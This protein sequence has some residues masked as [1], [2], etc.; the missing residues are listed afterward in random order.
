MLRLFRCTLAVYMIGKVLTSIFSPRLLF[1]TGFGLCMTGPTAE[2]AAS[3]D[4]FTCHSNHTSSSG[5]EFGFY[6]GDDDDETSQAKEQV[7]AAATVIT[8]TSPYDPS[9]MMTVFAKNTD[10]DAQSVCLSTTDMDGNTCEWCNLAGQADLCLTSEQADM[11]AA[12][13]LACS[14]SYDDDDE[15]EAAFAAAGAAAARV[16]DD[17]Y[18]PS[19]ALAF[20][21]DQTKEACLAAVDQDGKACEYCTLQDALAL[22][23]TEEQAEY[24]QA[25]GIECD[26]ATLQ[27]STLPEA[28]HDP[29]DSTCA[30]AFLQDQS[31][32]GCE[33]AVDQD[34]RACEWC[35]LPGSAGNIC[36]NTD[37]AE[38]AEQFGVTCN[39][40]GNDHDNVNDKKLRG[41]SQAE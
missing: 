36:L 20:L 25:M 13:G 41:V 35:D 34:G 14:N 19:C 22:C 16:V 23:L 10:D 17:P 3:S 33:A 7:E 30:L 1:I 11:G 21:Q 32:E 5:V 2:S 29:L 24:G 4:W 26:T 31:K 6:D 18:D 40:D 12:F 38:M 9:C 27:D 39:D 28:V 8:M 37:Q 15:E